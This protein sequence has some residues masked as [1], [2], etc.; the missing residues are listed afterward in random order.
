MAHLDPGLP[1]IA[2]GVCVLEATGM[3]VAILVLVA[4]LV[5]TCRDHPT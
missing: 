4:M 2:E 3:A 5:G 1:A